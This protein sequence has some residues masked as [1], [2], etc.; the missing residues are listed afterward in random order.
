MIKLILVTFLFSVGSNILVSQLSNYHWNWSYATAGHS[1]DYVA[2]L[3]E[4]KN[5]NIIICGSYEFSD[6]NFCKQSYNN[7]LVG[8]TFV[9]K[10]DNLGH[11]IWIKNLIS[12]YG[13]LGSPCVS[14]SKENKIF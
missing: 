3:V 12:Q 14:I 5:N 4:D 6:F 9:S 13:L 1:D 11:C 8:G 10:L 7:G 2:D